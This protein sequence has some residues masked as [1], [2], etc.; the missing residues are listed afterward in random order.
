MD[1]QNPA[2]YENGQYLLEWDPVNKNCHSEAARKAQADKLRRLMESRAP[3]DSLPRA[4]LASRRNQP[5]LHYFGFPYTTDFALRYAK[6]HHLTIEIHPEETSEFD[7]KDVFDFADIEDRHL[8]NPELREFFESMAPF[9]MRLDLRSKCKM[10]LEQG[11]PFALQWNGIIALWSNYNIRERYQLCP[12]YEKV[13]E[14]LRE[15]MN[16]EEQTSKLQW[17]FDW[18]NDVGVFRSVD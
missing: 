18:D 17:W 7:D 14:I 6:R 15:A 5:P 9:L 10:P 3:R 1:S 4:E 16:D 12:N 13:V 11:R 8:A 2:L